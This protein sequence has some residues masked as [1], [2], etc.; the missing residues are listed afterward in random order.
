MQWYGHQG[1]NNALLQ[2]TTAV[3]SLDG[4]ISARSLTQT[5]RC[6]CSATCGTPIALCA[7]W[8]SSRRSI[9]KKCSARGDWAISLTQGRA[10][11][12]TK[13]DRIQWQPEGSRNQKT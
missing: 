9:I 7:K 8:A 2:A 10:K 4:T 12:I 11:P 3:S 6:G 13:R 1:R 5:A